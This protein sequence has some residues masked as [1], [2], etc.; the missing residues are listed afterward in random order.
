MK[1]Y[2]LEVK[3]LTELCLFIY[4]FWNIEVN[5]IFFFLNSQNMC[6]NVASVKYYRKKILINFSY[7]ISFLYLWFSV[8]SRERKLLLHFWSVQSCLFKQICIKLGQFGVAYRFDT[9]K[10]F[11]LSVVTC[12]TQVLKHCVRWSVSP[13]ELKTTQ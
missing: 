3:G 1:S 9:S 5:T 12:G 13:K 11:T 2:L 8:I 7:Q 6:S 4:K 10:Q